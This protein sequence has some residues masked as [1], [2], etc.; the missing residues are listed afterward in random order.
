MTD[1]YNWGNKLT[2]VTIQAMADLGYLVDVS[3]AE[4]PLA[5][6]TKPA[7]GP[8]FICQ[9]GHTSVMGK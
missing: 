1:R 7:I 5:K 6:L 8:V 9:D 2:L 4:E 3:Q